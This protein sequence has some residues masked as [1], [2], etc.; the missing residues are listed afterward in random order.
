MAELIEISDLQRRRPS[1]KSVRSPKG[2]VK[3]SEVS[4]DQIRRA[5]KS[6]RMASIKKALSGVRIALIALSQGKFVEAGNIAVNAAIE[7][8]ASFKSD[9]NMATRIFTTAR[10]IVRNAIRGLMARSV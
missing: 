3:V 9:P 10:G 5:S 4:I 7:A 8:S 2:N 1:I 6:M